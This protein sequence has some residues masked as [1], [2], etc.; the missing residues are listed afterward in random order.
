MRSYT[1]IVGAIFLFVT[2]AYVANFNN[3]LTGIFFAGWIS[4]FP[5]LIDKLTGKHR[6]IGHSIFWLIPLAIVGFWN[7][8]IAVAIM[9]GFISHIF[10][11]ILTTNGCPV[12]YPLWKND[13]VCFGK[14]RRIKT[15]TNQEKAVFLVMLL[16]L[17]P[18]L[19]FTTNLVSLFENTGDENVVFAGSSE[20]V[21]SSINNDTMKNNFYLNFELKEGV[22][23]NISI[24]K[25]SEKE[26]NI[27]VTDI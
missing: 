4:V 11:D 17:I 14:K 8:G 22:N 16:L 2:F 19:F 12:L 3:L 21:N 24:K 18:F 1:H 5:D 9:I 6:G 15:G 23:K 7:M 25:V 13:F 27:L 10:L 20:S 26:T